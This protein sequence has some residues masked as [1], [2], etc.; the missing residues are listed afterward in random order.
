MS[1]IMQQCHRKVVKC[2]RKWLHSACAW[3]N[4]NYVNFLNSLITI[5]DYTTQLRCILWSVS[6][7][8]YGHLHTYIVL[9][10]IAAATFL[11]PPPS[12][13]KVKTNPWN[14]IVIS[15]H[16][17]CALTPAISPCHSDDSP[18]SSYRWVSSPKA[19]IQERRRR[20]CV[21]WRFPGTRWL[22]LCLALFRFLHL[23]GFVN[24]I[25]LS[26]GDRDNHQ[27]RYKNCCVVD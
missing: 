17:W 2:K 26:D 8:V 11:R 18:Q 27:M 24:L 4:L 12:T 25:R 20:Y 23:D 9:G 10:H 15:S 19:L 6:S 16:P 22:Y 3:W 13:F 21:L 14:S 5:I 1:Q 7:F